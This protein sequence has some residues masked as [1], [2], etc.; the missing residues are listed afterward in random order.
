MR[1]PYD[2]FARVKGRKRWRRC[3]AMSTRTWSESTMLRGLKS[4]IRPTLVAWSGVGVSKPL[5]QPGLRTD[6]KGSVFLLV[7]HRE[8]LGWPLQPR[9]DV[10]RAAPASPAAVY[11]VAVIGVGSSIPQSHQAIHLGA[12]WPLTARGASR[13]PAY[14]LRAQAHSLQPPPAGSPYR[15]PRLATNPLRHELPLASICP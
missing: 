1:S 12:H 9:S 3:L 11:S 15:D 2:S 8:C 7:H 13:H 14:G 10:I 4:W 5:S 6:A